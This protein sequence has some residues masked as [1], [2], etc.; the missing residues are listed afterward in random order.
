[1]QSSTSPSFAKRL[2]WVEPRGFREADL[3]GSWKSLCGII[4]LTAGAAAVFLCVANWFDSGADVTWKLLVT[5]GALVLLCIV[6]WGS[7]HLMQIIV[8]ITDKAI[9][10]E[11][12]DTPTV[13]RFGAVDH[14]EIRNASVGGRTMSV[15]V[16]AL[17]NGDR[18]TFGIAPSVRTEVLRSALEQRGVNVVTRSD[19]LSEQI[20]ASEK[21]DP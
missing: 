5:A 19:T 20:L 21:D 7:A 6:L 16:V 12:G 4:S 9:V 2:T 14:C 1:M 15:L 8:K 17:K 3:K 18:E 10:W 13:Y 11:L